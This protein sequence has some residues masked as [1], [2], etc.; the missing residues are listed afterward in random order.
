MFDC[1]YAAVQHAA[2]RNR[3]LPGKDI[4]VQLTGSRHRKPVIC[5][6]IPVDFT[7]YNNLPGDNRGANRTMFTNSNGTL[8]LNFTAE[9]ALDP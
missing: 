6:N 3:Q 9:I 7:G 8:A 1:G 4:A 5:D 2:F